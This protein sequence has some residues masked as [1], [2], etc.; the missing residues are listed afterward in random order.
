MKKLYMCAALSGLF[1]F[2]VCDNSNAEVKVGGVLGGEM[3]FHNDSEET[4][5]SGGDETNE[6][7][8][9]GGNL[10]G[11]LNADYNSE[12]IQ[13]HTQIK[14]DGRRADQPTNNPGN[15]WKFADDLYLQQIHIDWFFSENLN[16]RFGKQASLIAPLAPNDID[17]PVWLSHMGNM[18]FHDEVSAFR[19]NAKFGGQVTGSFLVGDPNSNNNEALAAVEGAKEENIIPR[20]DASVQYVT[21]MVTIIPAATFLTQTYDNLPEGYDDTINIW[22]TSLSAELRI[23]KFMFRAEGYYGQNLGD[24]NYTG[25]DGFAAY[26]GQGSSVLVDNQIYDTTTYGGFFEAMYT[27]DDQWS[28]GGAVGMATYKNND[29]PLEYSYDITDTGYAFTVHYMPLP[30]LIFAP[31]LRYYTFD[32]SAEV[33]GGTEDHGDSL[34][35]GFALVAIF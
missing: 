23:N 32:E 27:I 2:S 29:V 11:E 9:N 10:L 6:L 14:L 30:N 7:W 25:V 1:L 17:G 18:G 22:A 12:K 8:L 15:D 35:I 21:D 3:W 13:L 28:V 16:L 33:G 31:Q 26:A 19:L 24:G 4:R 20:M 34:E 5:M